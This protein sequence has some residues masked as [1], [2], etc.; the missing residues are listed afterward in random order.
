MGLKKH[1]PGCEDADCCCGPVT[2]HIDEFT[3]LWPC[4]FGQ[5]NAYSLIGDSGSVSFGAPPG[6][7]WAISSG[8]LVYSRPSS[9]PYTHDTLV[10]EAVRL[11][12]PFS[13]E[14]ILE[15]AELNVVSGDPAL[16]NIQMNDAGDGSSRITGLVTAGLIGTISP[17]A[18]RIM[19]GSGG[20]QAY[21]NPI[22]A[23][24][25]QIWYKIQVDTDGISHWLWIDGTKPTGVTW[26]TKVSATPPTLASTR[27]RYWSLQVRDASAARANWAKFDRVE[28]REWDHT[29]VTMPDPDNP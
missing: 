17:Q 18:S 1:N 23:T 11:P 24:P 8:Q 22:A 10:I 21:D 14:I 4:F 6:S 9:L 12:V 2:E 3:S 27:K 19:S 29:S 20:A 26:G 28:V 13:M 5:P 25:A 16:L 15:V 7:G